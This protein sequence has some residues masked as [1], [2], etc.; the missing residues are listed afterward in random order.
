MFVFDAT[1][2]VPIH[3][4]CENEI[5]FKNFS[6]VVLCDIMRGTCD[7]VCHA[8]QS[9]QTICNVW[10]LRVIVCVVCS[11]GWSTFEWSAVSDFET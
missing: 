4:L 11:V 5:V 10:A 2:C 8:S 6:C 9:A 7:T 1:A 3:A